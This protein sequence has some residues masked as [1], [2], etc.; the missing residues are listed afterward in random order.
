MHERAICNVAMKIDAWEQTTEEDNFL[1]VNDTAD[2]PVVH[3]KRQQADFKKV[4]SLFLKQE[5]RTGK[6]LAK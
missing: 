5:Q 3:G 2:S 4:A 1:S 6:F